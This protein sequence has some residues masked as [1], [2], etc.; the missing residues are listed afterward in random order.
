MPPFAVCIYRHSV[1]TKSPLQTFGL[2]RAY[3]RGTTFSY[4]STAAEILKRF[5][6]ALSCNGDKT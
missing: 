5:P 3:L 2:Q 1:Q 4:H 6:R